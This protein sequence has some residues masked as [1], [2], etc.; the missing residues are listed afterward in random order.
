MFKSWRIAKVATIAIVAVAVL[1][2]GAAS[3]STPGRHHHRVAPTGVFGIVA[4]VNGTTTAGTCGTADTAGTF[5]LTGAHSTTDTVN[6]STTTTFEEHG[7][8]TPTFANVCVGDK[9]GAFGMISSGTVTATGVFVTPQAVFGTV[10]S[11]NGTTTAGTC[12]TA[13]TA[14]TFALTGAHST[15]DTVNVSTTTTFEE[16]GVTTPTFANVCVGS[17]LGAFGA[18]TS[19]TLTATS[20]FVTPPPTPKPH[21][22]FG[23]VAS[24]NGTTTAGTCGSADTT[25]TFALTGAHSTT[26]TV[27]VSTTTTFE[28]HG[29][30]TPTF[31]NVCVGDKVGAFGIVSSGTV[32]ATAVFVTPPKPP[33]VFGTV[34]SVNG[35]TTAGTCGTADTAGTF[36][37]TGAHSTTDTVNVSTTTTFEEHGVTTPTFANVCVGSKVA[38]VGAM[39]SGTVTATSVFVTPTMMAPKPHADLGTH[40][41]STPGPKVDF[42]TTS[43]SG[44]FTNGSHAGHG[45]D[46][47]IG[48]GSG[49]STNKFHSNGHSSGHNSH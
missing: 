5:A 47:H 3:A 46:Y 29:V 10:A 20:V 1:S 21:A 8:T 36:A 23:T 15:T 37:L 26:D 42:G 31:A 38:A 49:G 12:G 48:F 45:S 16:H 2:S 32:A 35:T 41:A 43:T 18:L 28:E 19:G 4:S 27:N 24:V 34:A 40:K 9:V 7:V 14:G 33:V 22:V 25:G 17:K 11:V 39:T 6:V 13:D 44:P 30:T